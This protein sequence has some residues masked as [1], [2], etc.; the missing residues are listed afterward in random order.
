MN[1]RCRMIRI[2]IWLL[3]GAI[4][5]FCL[6]ALT[7]MR[8]T[9]A[10][11][12]FQRLLQKENP[13]D[14]TLTVY[15]TEN[16]ILLTPFPWTAEILMKNTEDSKIVVRGEGLEKNLEMFDKIN[17][18]TV[19]PILIGTDYMHACVHYVL[20]SKVNGKILEV[21]TSGIGGNVLL[22]GVKL[23]YDTVFEEIIAPYIP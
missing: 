14:L 9:R 13:A 11:L 6:Y 2:I 10:A 12:E 19:K 8:Y 3:V 16:G 7:S 20:E 1:K 4:V 18:S 21:T 23:Q 22:N 17:D 15:R 5:A